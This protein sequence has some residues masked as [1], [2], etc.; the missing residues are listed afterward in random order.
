MV[1]LVIPAVVCAALFGSQRIQSHAVAERQ[2]DSVVTR[3]MPLQP[4]SRRSTSSLKKPAARLMNPPCADRLTYKTLNPRLTQQLRGLRLETAQQL[5]RLQYRAA[6]VGM[7]FSERRASS[8][9]RIRARLNSQAIAIRLRHIDQL[10]TMVPALEQQAVDSDTGLIIRVP[11][12]STLTGTAGLA[13]F[14]VDADPEL[15]NISQRIQQLIQLSPQSTA[16]TAELE[17]SKRLLARLKRIAKNTEATPAE[18]Q[19]I[20]ELNQRIEL[21]RRRIAHPELVGMQDPQFDRPLSFI[22]GSFGEVLFR[23]ETQRALT[24]ATLHG[25][26]LELE[27]LPKHIDRL[28]SAWTQG[29]AT[30]AE[31]TAAS[32]REMRLQSLQQKSLADV[33]Q[34]ESGIRMLREFNRLPSPHELTDQV[35]LP[36]ENGLRDLVATQEAQAAHAQ[37]ALDAH[38]GVAESVQTLSAHDDFFAGEARRARALYDIAMAQSDTAR[39]RVSFA[40]LQLGFLNALRNNSDIWHALTGLLTAERAIIQNEIRALTLQHDHEVELADSTRQV[41]RS[42]HASWLEAETAQ[43][44]VE[45]LAARIALRRVRL[46]VNGLELSRMNLLTGKAIHAASSLVPLPRADL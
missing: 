33:R 31:L 40:R 4:A 29:A 45:R 13:W 27:R 8:M 18:S 5:S 7:L 28:R 26:R 38:D 22:P 1:R 9:E 44:N 20:V 23:L 19:R 42:G 25:L 2:Q 3:H 16:D 36:A 35:L 37:A 17:H 39:S 6:T 46:D 11:G 32:Q 12:F 41:Q 14:R 30:Q 21:L 15:Q 34:L 24:A 43:L 10:L